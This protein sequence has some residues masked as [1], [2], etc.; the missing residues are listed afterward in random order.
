[1]F[2]D[3]R[4]LFWIFSLWLM[5]TALVASWV[6]AR[7]RYRGAPSSGLTRTCSLLICSLGAWK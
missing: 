2:T 7:Y 4:R 6:T 5:T 3:F 1:A